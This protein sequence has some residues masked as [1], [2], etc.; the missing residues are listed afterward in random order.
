M[1]LNQS[2]GAYYSN[3]SL[4]TMISVIHTRNTLINENP[5]FHYKLLHSFNDI[6]P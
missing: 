3:T 4:V 6:L 1:I 5:L 2:N